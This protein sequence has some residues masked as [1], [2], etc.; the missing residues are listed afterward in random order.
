MIN[1]SDHSQGCVVERHGV[2]ALLVTKCSTLPWLE[3]PH[4]LTWIQI[5]SREVTE[6]MTGGNQG[7]ITINWIRFVAILL[8]L[9][10]TKVPFQGAFFNN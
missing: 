10:G 8:P 3:W 9:K 5:V 1:G 2:R 7:G 4:L 6:A